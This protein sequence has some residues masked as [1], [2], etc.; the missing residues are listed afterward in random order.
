MQTRSP[1]VV[2]RFR[3]TDAD[4]IQLTDLFAASVLR[5]FGV[6]INPWQRMIAEEVLYRVL[7]RKRHTIV[8]AICR[9]VGKT[10]VVCYLLWFLSYVFPMVEGEKFKGVITA[11]ERGTG[12][13]VYDRTKNLFDTCENR[14]PSMF[15]FKQ[16]NLDAIQLHNNTR[17]EV[18]GLFKGFA[19]REKKK[20][21]KE[22]RT[23]HVA[24]RDEMHLGEDEIFKDD[25]EPALSTTGGVDILLGNGG[26]RSCRGRDLCEKGAPD[27]VTYLEDIT[28]FRFTYEK[29]RPWALE[30]YD[31]TGNELW[32][33]W[34][35]SQD[36]YIEDNGRDDDAVRK[37]LFC[38]WLVTVGN[39]V[40]EMELLKHARPAGYALK[41]SAVDVGI[42]WAKES[43]ETVL[44]ITDYERNIR[45]WATFYGE[46]PDQVEEIAEWL[47]QRL[48]ELGLTARN[49]ICDTTG[50]GDPVTSMLKRKL[51]M[52]V[53]GVVFGNATKDK[54]AKKAIAVINAKR[55]EERFTYP[56]EHPHRVKFETQM[57]KLQKERRKNTG[58]LNYHHP[59]ENGA[60]DDYPD[61]FFLS[62]WKMV[63]ESRTT[64]YRRNDIDHPEPREA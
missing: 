26:Y 45:D 34:V 21:T 2:G 30:E 37:N 31:R 18:F 35:N 46:Y 32:L 52:R 3:K 33:R 15:T 9:Q 13:E 40:D 43:D 48:A 51:R 54:L 49:V 19:T 59:A 63:K 20:S 1:L 4:Y 27:E 10:E 38:E 25:I 64:T 53:S 22:G 42:D 55:E 62:L 44:T 61:S 23:Y 41:E 57:R 24:V 39:F 7:Q 8:I 6:V 11:P 17:L 12:S 50:A 56:A 60:K 47:P 14:W 28:V 5:F 36:K 58:Q 29:M 16:K